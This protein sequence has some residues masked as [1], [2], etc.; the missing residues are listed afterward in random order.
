MKTR[1]SGMPEE[2]LW[3]TFFRPREALTALGLKADARFA[4]EFG[5][6]YGTFSLEAA[7]MI[8]GRVLGFDIEPGLV[9]LCRRKAVGAGL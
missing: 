2:A 7:R 3:N 4:V 8:Q 9:D 6:G 5:S 1:E